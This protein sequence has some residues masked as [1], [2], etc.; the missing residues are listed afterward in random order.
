MRIWDILRYNVARLSLDFLLA[1]NNLDASSTAGST[2]LHDIHVL[3]ILI[4]S[5][6]DELAVVIWEQV[7]LWTKVILLEHSAHST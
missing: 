5:I 7:S 2:W 1:P 6:H 3:I 4:L